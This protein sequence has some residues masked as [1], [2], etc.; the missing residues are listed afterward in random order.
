MDHSFVIKTTKFLAQELID[1]KIEITDDQA[2]L[3][4]QDLENLPITQVLSSHI[5]ERLSDFY[6]RKWSSWAN[7]IHQLFYPHGRLIR[8]NMYTVEKDL[9]DLI[10][11]NI[12]HSGQLFQLP[13]MS[14][15]SKDH[16]QDLCENMAKCAA[17]AILQVEMA[18]VVTRW[19]L[20]IE[21][22]GLDMV[23][24]IYLAEAAGE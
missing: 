10:S 17:D 24:P 4:D 22:H 20:K 3:D 6:P 11:K 23:R 15:S 8:K 18:A 19:K 16:E 7:L 21:E 1:S 9:Q 14:Q 5:I 2:D 12:H 13:L